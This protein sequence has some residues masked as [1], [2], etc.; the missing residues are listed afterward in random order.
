M[1]KSSLKAHDS[2]NSGTGGQSIKNWR[3]FKI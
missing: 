2:S 3:V 1:G